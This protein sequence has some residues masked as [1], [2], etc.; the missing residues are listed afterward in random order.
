MLVIAI[1]LCIVLG[2]GSLLP[3]VLLAPVLALTAVMTAGVGL[4]VSALNVYFRDVEH[5]LAAVGLPWIF[6]S[7][8]FWTPANFEQIAPGLKDNQ[9]LLDLLYYANPPAPFIIGMQKILFFGVWP[10]MTDVVYCAIAGT[11]V[12]A[13][14]W[15]IFRRMERDLAIEL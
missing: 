15:L 7:P 4:L 6:V 10:S 8:I 2:S 5:I 14:G 3:L 9:F 13:L 11:V 12:L 1:P